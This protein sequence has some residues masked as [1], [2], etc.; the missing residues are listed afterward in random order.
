MN[1]VTLPSGRSILHLELP[2]AFRRKLLGALPTHIPFFAR[3]QDPNDVNEVLARERQGLGLRPHA[4]YYDDD[5]HSG[6]FFFTQSPVVTGDAL[7]VRFDA[8]DLPEP[9]NTLVVSG[10]EVVGGEFGASGLVGLDAVQLRREDAVLARNPDLSP[11]GLYRTR[12]TVGDPGNADG[13]PVGVPV[14]TVLVD[15]TDYVA[16]PSVPGLAENLFGLAFLNPGDTVPAPGVI[17]IG[18]SGGGEGFIG[19]SS[20]LYSRTLPVVGF[21][22]DDLEIRLDVDG[23]LSTRAGGQRRTKRLDP[24]P[25]WRIP[26][27]YQVMEENGRIVK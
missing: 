22:D 7:L 14:T 8:I 15:F 17:A 5:S 11:Q 25:P 12:G 20:T 10:I 24:L 1:P 21:P 3:L 16:T 23:A 18:S 26:G 6:G 13:V 4:G 9:G 27:V 2:R 19:N